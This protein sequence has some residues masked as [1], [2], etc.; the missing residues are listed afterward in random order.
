MSILYWLSI[1]ENTSI[2][3]GFGVMREIRMIL[4]PTLFT[5]CMYGI[6]NLCFEIIADSDISSNAG[7]LWL[8]L[9]LNIMQSVSFTIIYIQCH[10]VPK[11]LHGALHSSRRLLQRK[12]KRRGSTKLPTLASSNSN[13]RD[14]VSSERKLSH[15]RSNSKKSLSRHSSN[16][17]GSLNLAKTPSH[18]GSRNGNNNNNNNTNS[19][20]AKS[21]SRRKSQDVAGIEFTMTTV[22][23][24]VGSEEI[25]TKDVLSNDEGFV[26]LMEH[27]LSEFSGEC[28]FAFVEFTQYLDFCSKVFEIEI[29]TS[30]V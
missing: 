20:F 10:W 29:T 2:D 24:G 21:K 26:I 19:S 25:S 14:S 16:S 18:S 30:L 1:Q 22:A 13:L 7:F 12:T 9:D 3:D 27:L 8:C 28:L 11:H 15:S 4:P 5:A 23:T 17:S 6:R